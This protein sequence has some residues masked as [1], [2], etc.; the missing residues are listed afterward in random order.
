MVLVTAYNLFAVLAYHDLFSAAGFLL[1][2]LVLGY[3]WLELDKKDKE[4]K[5]YYG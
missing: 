2:V 3:M 1:G 4:Y 5:R